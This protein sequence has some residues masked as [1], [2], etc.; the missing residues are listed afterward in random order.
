MTSYAFAARRLVLLAAIG[1]AS[2]SSTSFAAAAAAAEPTAGSGWRSDLDWT[3][4]ESELSPSASLID[5]SLENYSEECLP[6]FSEPS[7][8]N[9]ALIDQ[10]SG[11]CLPHL[12]TAWDVNQ[13]DIAQIFQD[14]VRSGMQMSVLAQ[15]FLNVEPDYNLPSKV[16]FPSVAS[17]VIHAI[18]FA[19]KHNLEIS[20]KNSGHSYS[21]ASSKKNT[22][23][24][25]MN[26]YT[27]YAPGGITDCDPAL[28]GTAV[29]DDLSNQA[30]LLALARGKPG[31]IRVGGGENYG[32]FLTL[33][34]LL[35]SDRG[36]KSSDKSSHQSAQT[37]TT[38]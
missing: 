34:S 19:E 24:L 29:A 25:N 3:E 16:L 20:I 37:F 22:L 33:I 7:P 28:L 9:H 21:G 12:I 5:T 30:C 1:C 8:T 36:N 38:M 15:G 17:D 2:N 26:R 14:F 4:L 11:M 10:P 13:I 6:E 35:C 31:V 18:R 27:H 32:K 23:H